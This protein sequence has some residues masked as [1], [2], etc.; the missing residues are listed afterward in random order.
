MD[1]FDVLSNLA[2]TKQHIVLLF[3]DAF[4][5][6]AD[7][8]LLLFFAMSEVEEKE[9]LA[10]YNFPSAVADLLNVIWDDMLVFFW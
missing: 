7:D 4:L 3:F 2:I 8:V 10:A 9:D 5:F 6:K 1:H